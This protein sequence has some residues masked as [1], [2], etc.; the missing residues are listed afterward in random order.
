MANCKITRLCPTCGNSFTRYRSLKQTYCGRP[1]RNTSLRKGPDMLGERFLCALN[2]TDTCW[3]WTGRTTPQGYGKLQL[4]H[5]NI[6]WE[7][8][9]R[10]S[11]MFHFGTIPDG[12]CVLHNCPGGDNRLCCNPDHLWLGTRPANNRDRHRKGRDGF[13]IGEAHPN[14]KLTDDDVYA[15]RRLLQTGVTKVAIGKQFGVS[16]AVIYGIHI[17][18]GWKHLP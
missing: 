3:L 13:K 10:L 9:H 6:E 8:T 15:I 1:C 7:Q 11:W 2:K 14:A 12:L 18:T 4:A 17:G 16:D 5:G